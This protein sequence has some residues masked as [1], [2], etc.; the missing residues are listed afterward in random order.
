M[1]LRLRRFSFA[2]LGAIGAIGLGLVVFVSQLGWPGVFS[3][4]IPSSTAR[5]GTIHDA[6]ALAHAPLAVS[7]AR[8][9]RAVSPGAPTTTAHRASRP[10]GEPSLGGSHRFVA[11]PGPQPNPGSEPPAASPPAAPEGQS[12]PSSNAAD[13]TSPESNPGQSKQSDSKSNS[14]SS[15]QVKSAGKG[16][17]GGSATGGSKGRGHV[18]RTRHSP[19]PSK[20]SGPLAEK[21]HGGGGPSSAKAVAPTPQAPEKESGGP[22]GPG[23]G[24]EGAGPGKSDEA[25]H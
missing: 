1:L 16:R 23:G 3:S 17:S 9:A 6:I 5:V 2:L 11:S 20:S 24:K 7:S 4:P 25:H 19:S 13:E 21:S 14:P 15:T 22:T 18:T 8:R 12:P 10:G